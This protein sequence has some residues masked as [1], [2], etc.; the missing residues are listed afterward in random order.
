[1]IMIIALIAYVPSADE[2][3]AVRTKAIHALTFCSNA[4]AP[5]ADDAL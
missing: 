3:F 1:M 2:P 4:H 5:L